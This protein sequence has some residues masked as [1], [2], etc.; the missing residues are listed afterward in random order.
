M[1]ALPAGW[2]R[3]TAPDGRHYY[4]DHSTQTTSWEPPTM[5]VA[6]PVQSSKPKLVVGAPFLT[7]RSGDQPIAQAVA[8]PPP[9]VVVNAQPPAPPGVVVNAQPAPAPPPAPRPRQQPA[10]DRT[11]TGSSGSGAWTRTKALTKSLIV[12]PLAPSK[13]SEAGWLELDGAQRWVELRNGILAIYEDRTKEY[14]RF[15]A[16]MKFVTVV[17]DAATRTTVRAGAYLDPLEIALQVD[18]ERMNR[19]ADHQ[20]HGGIPFGF[21]DHLRVGRQEAETG[22]TAP[23]DV[24][25][26][27]FSLF[28]KTTA[29]KQAWRTTLNTAANS[30]RNW[31]YVAHE[32][33]DSWKYVSGKKK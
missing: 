15:R 21:F 30:L 19:E 18:P 24:R 26:Q 29:E 13:L 10:S 14:L 9:G 28:A 31:A 32:A 11:T 1:S 8:Q 17:A 25:R 3:R 23:P 27:R 20:N 33:Q 22:L 4:V 7:V 16:P 5:P 6:Q 12:G 2:E